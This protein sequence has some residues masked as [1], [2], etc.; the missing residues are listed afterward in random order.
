MIWTPLQK[1]P[2]N[3]DDLDKLIVAKCF[4]SCP[5]CKKSPNLITL[6]MIKLDMHFY[7]KKA[8]P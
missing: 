1:L 5:K 3:V 6:F 2:N 7:C 4:K 8:Y